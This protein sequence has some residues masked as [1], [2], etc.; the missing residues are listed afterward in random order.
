MTVAEFIK[1]YD[2][3]DIDVYGDYTDEL[4]IAYC[5][6]QLTPAGEK[7]FADIL[8]LSVAIEKS[9]FPSAT[10]H[11]ENA[12]QERLVKRLFIWAAGYCSQNTFDKFFKEI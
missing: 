5:G 7:E 2:G 8:S 9:P 10:V 3:Q 11:I 12:R 1:N 6:A 4:A